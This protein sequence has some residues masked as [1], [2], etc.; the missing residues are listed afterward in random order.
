MT[1]NLVHQVGEGNRETRIHSVGQFVLLAAAAALNGL[2]SL[3]LLYG[4]SHEALGLQVFGSPTLALL[5]IVWLK[6]GFSWL[7]GH[8][9]AQPS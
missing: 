9:M 5:W 6:S 1:S 8:P 3:G 4:Y 7:R 2:L